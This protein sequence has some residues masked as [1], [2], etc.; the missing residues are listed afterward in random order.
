MLH[1]T[2]QDCPYLPLHMVCIILRSVLFTDSTLR[3]I[4][5]EGKSHLH[6]GASLKSYICMTLPHHFQRCS[7]SAPDT[8]LH[9]KL[10][11]RENSSWM[12]CC[13]LP[14]QHAQYSQHMDDT[15][16]H[17]KQHETRTALQYFMRVAIRTAQKQI[18]AFFKFPWQC[19]GASRESDNSHQLT[20]LP[21]GCHAGESPKPT[22]SSRAQLLCV[23]CGNCFFQ[24]RRWKCKVPSPV[25]WVTCGVRLE[26]CLLWPE[27]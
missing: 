11:V 14:L 6:R 9:N 23:H 20:Y 26:Q 5:E 3:E 16:L 12:C 25:D 21:Q 17:S 8:Q 2:R 19:V 18:N 27:S 7:V 22:G 1:K 24:D 13:P 10:L 4:P 15:V